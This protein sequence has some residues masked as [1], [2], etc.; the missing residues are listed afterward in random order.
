MANYVYIYTFTFTHHDAL[1][2]KPHKVC[3]YSSEPL[4]E[5]YCFRL[6]FNI[7]TLVYLGTLNNDAGGNAKNEA[8]IFICLVRRLVKKPPHT[9]HVM[10]RINFKRKMCKISRRGPRSPK[11]VDLGYL[12]FLQTFTGVLQKTIHT[13][14]VF[15]ETP[16]NYIS[17]DRLLNVKFDKI[18]LS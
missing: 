12:R 14:A 7:S 18:V 15:K 11:C 6:N 17:I 1:G 3:S 9:E 4:I 13:P 5:V 8:I 10:P 16:T 2:N